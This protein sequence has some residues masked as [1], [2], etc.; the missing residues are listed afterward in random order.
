MWGY[1][2]YPNYVLD[3]TRNTRLA[4]IH[5]AMTASPVFLSSFLFYLFP[6]TI[7]CAKGDNNVKHGQITWHTDTV[8]T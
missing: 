6:T 2:K 4:T 3:N 7:M 5:V 1:G 8:E